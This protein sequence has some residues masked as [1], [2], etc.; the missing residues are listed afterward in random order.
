MCSIRDI[1]DKGRKSSRSKQL[2]YE[3]LMFQQPIRDEST[4]EPELVAKFRSYFDALAYANNLC[5]APEPTEVLIR[6]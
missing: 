5:K 2:R 6:S 3:V 1:S 4:E